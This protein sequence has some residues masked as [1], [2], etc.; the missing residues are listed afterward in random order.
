MSCLNLNF[1][2][3][4]FLLAFSVYIVLTTAVLHSCL[5]N[6]DMNIY[7]LFFIEKFLIFKG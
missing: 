6:I 5:I 2:K 7:I 3:I 4:V 1:T